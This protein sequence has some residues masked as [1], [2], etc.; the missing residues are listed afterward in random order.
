[1]LEAERLKRGQPRPGSASVTSSAHD[2]ASASPPWS[3]A[4]HWI[5]SRG[6][7]VCVEG[8]AIAAIR[9][10]A[11]MRNEL[12]GIGASLGDAVEL[13]ERLTTPRTERATEVADLSARAHAKERLH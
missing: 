1:M 12:R 11:E 13:I 10:N 9:R 6:H 7:A 3:R 2:R 5:R 4:W 8:I